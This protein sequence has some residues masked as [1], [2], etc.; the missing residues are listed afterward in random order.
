[1]KIIV[2]VLILLMIAP[3]LYAD[4]YYNG[5]HTPDITYDEP[6]VPSSKDSGGV[7]LIA[8]GTMLILMGVIN[9][10]GVNQ[11]N[12]AI[13]IGVVIDAGGIISLIKW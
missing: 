7:G 1:M 3:A 10:P 5:S 4:T 12:L 9:G 13:D 2:L 11:N 6:I 8:I